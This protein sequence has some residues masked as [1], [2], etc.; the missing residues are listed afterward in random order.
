MP[1]FLLAVFRTKA[2]SLY[3][4][5]MLIYQ[6]MRS[7]IR[8]VI[9][10]QERELPHLIKQGSIARD[11]GAELARA[12]SSPLIKV[13]TGPRRAGKSTLALQTLSNYKFAYFNFEDEQLPAD[14][15]PALLIEVLDQVYGESDYIFFDE[16]QN[17]DR[18]E[19]LL[20]RLHR[21]GRNLIV[22]GSNAKL[23][24]DEL[25]TALTG[26]HIAIELLPLSLRETYS[27]IRETR[28]L[29]QR[30]LVQGGFPEVILGKADFRSYLSALWDSVILKDIVKRRRVRNVSELRDLLSLALSAMGSRQNSER[31]SL[32]LGGTASPPTVKKF[33]SYGSDAYLISELHRYHFKPRQRLKA[34]R[35][36]YSIDNGYF[37]AK[38]V[39]VFQEYSKLLENLVFV[40]LWRRGY[41]PNLDLFYYETAT[42]HEVDFLV[43]Q[44]AKNIELI[45]VSYEMGSQKTRDRE[46]RALL[47]AGKELN[48]SELT[49]ISANE[50]REERF[51]NQRIQILPF[52]EWS[53]GD[54]V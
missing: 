6:N 41:K 54:Y 43:R 9:L 4:G 52:V 40:E 50:R 20:N 2:I 28:N 48:V 3:F 8:N 13:I 18:W 15:D 32:G 53:L 16:I 10:K 26:R 14:I 44:G 29:D 12:L 36:C 51:D 47:S 38:Q 46:Y 34:D 11:K 5:I 30:Y 24:S 33:M 25:A 45:Q 37:S 27:T 42:G 22:T 35:K 23:L 1:P 7:L 49:I 31:L 19:P 17:L 39:G 21:G